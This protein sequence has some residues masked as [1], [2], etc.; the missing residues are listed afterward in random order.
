MLFGNRYEDILRISK[1][2]FI[3][4]INTAISEELKVIL[5]SW[6]DMMRAFLGYPPDKND[7]RKKC[8]LN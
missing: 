3:L 4:K 5:L 2:E 6:V 1:P 7:W 8:R